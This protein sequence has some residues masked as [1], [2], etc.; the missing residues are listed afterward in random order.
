MGAVKND[1]KVVEV[2][3]FIIAFSHRHNNHSGN[4]KRKKDICSKSQGTSRN[5]S[6]IQSRC[7]LISADLDVSEITKW[8]CYNLSKLPN[9][10]K[11]LSF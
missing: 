11:S 2:Y 6:V 4:T 8:H 7:S 3:L 5:L 9:T 10:S 1:L